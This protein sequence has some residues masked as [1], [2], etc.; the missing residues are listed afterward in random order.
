L[1]EG[2]WYR[3]PA[4]QYENTQV[5][6]AF[7]IAVCGAGYCENGAYTST[8]NWTDITGF[9]APQAID[10]AQYIQIASWNP[11]LDGPQSLSAQEEQLRREHSRFT[12]G[13]MQ[14]MR[15]RWPSQMPIRAHRM[16]RRP[17]ADS[18][19]GPTPE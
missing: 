19:G 1:N 16:R 12:P 2:Y 3:D 15:V 10:D 4:H 9:A 7:M 11:P 8:S 13:N 5:I 18:I 14:P 6:K 17:S